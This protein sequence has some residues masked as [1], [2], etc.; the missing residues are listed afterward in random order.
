LRL[1]GKH[2]L[3]LG[4]CR[5]DNMTIVVVSS[6]KVTNP[7]EIPEGLPADTREYLVRTIQL[8]LLPGKIKKT[9][10]DGVT[11]ADVFPI[12]WAEV[13]DGTAKDQD[14]ED[15]PLIK[16]VDNPEMATL[17]RQLL[18]CVTEQPDGFTEPRKLLDMIDLWLGFLPALEAHDA[19]PVPPPTRYTATVGNSKHP[20]YV[21]MDG[22]W[23]NGCVLRL[24]NGLQQVVTLPNPL[25]REGY[26]AKLNNGTQV[27]IR[28][29]DIYEMT[30]GDLET[31]ERLTRPPMLAAK[32]RPDPGMAF[33]EELLGTDNLREN[34]GKL[35]DN[36]KKQR[37]LAHA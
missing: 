3:I 20:L 2:K 11:A 5:L 27:T 24:D 34:A 9:M 30:R 18:D 12:F 33:I 15:I 31:L 6:V 29:E 37:L 36:L 7:A 10:R 8:R 4:K 16:R 35:L 22:Q 19:R 1:K 28:Q 32:L 21:D 14:G 25:P 23:M 17:R 26:T 13:E